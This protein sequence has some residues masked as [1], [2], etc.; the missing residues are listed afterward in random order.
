MKS[1]ALC[2]LP[3]EP[4]V[5]PCQPAVMLRITIIPE[6]KTHTQPGVVNHLT[7]QWSRGS[8]IA[9]SPW[10]RLAILARR[11]QTRLAA[12][13]IYAVS[14]SLRNLT[15]WGFFYV[16]RLHPDC[17]LFYVSV[18]DK[19]VPVVRIFVVAPTNTIFNR[20]SVHKVLTYHFLTMTLLSETDT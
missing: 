1:L 7:K 3:G 9:Y 18:S 19:R 17:I 14:V 5:T 16:G 11:S 13:T 6:G 15:P 10:A 2:N 20:R 8:S 12:I 4:S